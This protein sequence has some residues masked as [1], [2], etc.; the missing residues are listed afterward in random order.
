M[1]SG[2]SGPSATAGPEVLGWQASNIFKR[3]VIV[4]N[5]YIIFP[6][7]FYFFKGFVK[8]WLWES[9]L[10][11]LNQEHPGHVKQ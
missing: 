9:K 6:V 8:A 7:N 5:L 4:I 2:A 11:T 3:T 1:Y 10:S